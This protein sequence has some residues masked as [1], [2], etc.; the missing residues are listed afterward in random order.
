[1]AI[2]KNKKAR[3]ESL[4]EELRSR[5]YLRRI[6]ETLDSEWLPED[7]PIKT[8]KLNGFFKL[9][10]KSLPDARESPITLTM[11]KDETSVLERARIVSNAMLAG[12]I[13]A[14]QAQAAIAVLESV[15][16]IS[17][18]GDL[19]QRISAL[20]AQPQGYLTNVD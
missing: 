9:L 4:R 1:M 6:H 12:D 16:R 10:A 14:S 5:E 13:T 2:T 15:A 3:R 20:E 11:P 7:V 17:T 19:E 8:A 18:I